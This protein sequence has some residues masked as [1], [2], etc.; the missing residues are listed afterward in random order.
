MRAHKVNAYFQ[1]EAR[2]CNREVIFADMLFG[3]GMVWNGT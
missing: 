2:T 1:L 3:E